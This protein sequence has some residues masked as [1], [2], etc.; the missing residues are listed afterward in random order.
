MAISAALILPTTDRAWST[1]KQY[2]RARRASPRRPAQRRRRIRRPRPGRSE[3][4]YSGKSQKPLLAALRPVN[5]EYIR[6]VMIIVLARP[7]RSP[8]TPNI[9]PPI[10][11][12]IRKIAV[13]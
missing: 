1:L 12:P 11:Q 6:I 4:R 7:T 5:T 13:A 2:G 8:M 9:K 3:K 10:A